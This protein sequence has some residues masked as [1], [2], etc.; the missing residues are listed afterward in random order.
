MKTPY[1]LLYQSERHCSCEFPK[2]KSAFLN[3]ETGTSLIWANLILLIPSFHG[4]APAKRS[5]IGNRVSFGQRYETPQ[6]SD[7][8]C[9]Y[10][11]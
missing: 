10:K 2:K 1:S 9:Q 8:F 5:N 11:Q 4:F 7:C 3:M 6:I